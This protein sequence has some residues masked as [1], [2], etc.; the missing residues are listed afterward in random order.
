MDTLDTWLVIYERMVRIRRFEEAGMALLARGE[1]SGG[2]HTSVGQ[3]AAVVGACVA[4]ADDDYM[5]GTH[6]SHG[7]PIA[8]GAELAPLMAELLGK[9]TGVCRGKGGSLHLADF[10]VGSLGESGI[11]GSGMPVAVGAG[12]S[13][14]VRGSGQVALCFFGDGAASEGA[15]HESLNLAAVWKLPVI[16]LCENN[17]WACTVPASKMM[18][19]EDVAARADGL[20]MPGV[21]VDG[22]DALAVHA[23]VAEAAAR[24]R[25]GGGPTLVEA[26]TYRFREHSEGLALPAYRDEDTVAAWSSRDPID[27][28]RAKILKAGDHQAELDEIDE[29]VARDVD[30]A[31]E[32]ALE[33]PFPS[34]EALFE[35]LYSQPF[36]IDRVNW[37]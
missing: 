36:E 37:S 4:L 13:A 18:A 8:K 11:V 10:S 29:R 22:Q 1:F 16:F 5:T 19:V 26:K 2:F 3:E 35:D 33:S 30:A 17:G 23:A 21:I 34:L 14:Q 27:L 7:H 28:H 9:S 20:G 25:S 12:L 24:A 31:V 32:F 15:A 6:R